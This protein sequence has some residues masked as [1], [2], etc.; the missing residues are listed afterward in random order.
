MD[1]YAHVQKHEEKNIT[2]LCPN[3]H[4]NKTSGR[5]TTNAV[6]AYNAKPFNAGKNFT[7]KF[8][9][10]AFHT[11]RFTAI[12]GGNIFQHT[13][14]NGATLPL[15]LIE[16]HLGIS[17]TFED[18]VALLN[19]RLCDRKGEVVLFCD[20]GEVS[21]STRVWDYTLQGRNLVIKSDDASIAVAF[22]FHPTG[23]EIK[24]AHM[25]A[26]SGFS[27]SVNKTSI[28][29]KNGTYFGNNVMEDSCINIIGD[30]VTFPNTLR[31]NRRH[32]VIGFT[33]AGV[34]GMD[35][36]CWKIRSPK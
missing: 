31:I 29:A 26:P 25:F 35:C 14:V 3:H 5:I 8:D 24:S 12:V 10:G 1:N 30:G 2:L 36:G 23:I 32:W 34:I 17:I 28:T 15:L 4:Q 33:V 19:L 7:S 6:R 22:E 20:R 27:I 13:L 11:N 21:I 18:G 9:V 16:M